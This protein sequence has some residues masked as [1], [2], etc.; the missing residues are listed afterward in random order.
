MTPLPT[1]YPFVENNFERKNGVVSYTSY[2]FACKDS[3]S[4]Q[5]L[6]Q[7]INQSTY[8]FIEL[9]DLDRDR[10][11]LQMALELVDSSLLLDDLAEHESEQFLVIP[12]LCEVL[13]EALS[14]N[15]NIQHHSKSPRP[16][17]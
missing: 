9:G 13:A 2:S 6:L 15:I 3:R 16:S 5:R 12:R 8:T 10:L 14:P 17:C 1:V 4:C 7:A 11:G